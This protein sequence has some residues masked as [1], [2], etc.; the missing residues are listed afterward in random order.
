MNLAIFL[1]FKESMAIQKSVGQDGRFIKYYLEPYS[2]E[3]EK[4]YVFGWANE[5]YD[6]PFKNVFLVPNKKNSSPYWYSLTLPFAHKK[7]LEECRV[8]RLMQFTSVVPAAISKFLYKNKIVATYGFPYGRFLKIRGHNL[9]SFVWA[10]IER[11]L[12][13]AADKFIATYQK[14]SDHLSA[15]CVPLEKINLL[16]NGVDVDVFKPLA[17]KPA[18]KKTELLFV[19]RFEPEKNILNLAKSLG[20]IKSLNFHVTLIGRGALEKDIRKILDKEGISYDIIP[21]LSH[22]KLISKYQSADIFLLPSLAE[23]YPKVLVEAMACGLPCI[24]GKYPGYSDIITDGEN[25]V[26]CGFEP[27]SI[28]KAIGKLA[29]SPELKRRLSQNSR[30]FVLKNNDIKKIVEREIHIISSIK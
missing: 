6:F 14:T 9:Q 19:G 25:G 28:A 27:E 10:V 12:L 18:N 13:P 30:K 15:R 16:P 7:E 21:M 29:A 1:S 2:R 3:F 23:G 5:T 24:V 8:I 11:L 17:K 4:I 22:D 26:V 20:L